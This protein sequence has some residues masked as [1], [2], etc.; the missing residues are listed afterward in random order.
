MATLSKKG[1]RKRLHVRLR[2]KVSGT[3]ERPRFSVSFTGK[4]I[5][6]Q[7]INDETG[8]TLVSVMTT[9][10]TLAPKT[11]EAAIK[12]NAKGAEE[13]GKLVAERAKAKN[14]AKVVFDRGGFRYHGKVK[15]LADAARAAGLDF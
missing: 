8:K 10:K 3:D 12:P 7:I 13:V 2:R 9:E 11:P 15:A 6:A 14:I 1:T 4:H 5:Y